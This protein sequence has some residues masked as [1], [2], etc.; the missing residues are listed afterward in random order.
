MSRIKVP[1]VVTVDFETHGIERRPNYPPKPVGV[2]IQYPG[3]RAPTYFAWA[4]PAEN[5][6]SLQE[7]IKQVQRAWKSGLPLL[8]QNGKFD[9]DVAETHCAVKR[10]EWSM[11]HDTLFLIFLYDPHAR[12]FSLKPSAEKILGIT[13]D[14]RDA[15]R[16]WVM[17]HKREIEH[18]YGK[19]LTPKEWGAY[20]SEAPGKLVGRYAQGDVIRTLKLFKHLYPQIA[21]AGMLEAYDRER[22]LM[23]ILLEN[24]RV[25]MRVDVNTLEHDVKEYR[26]C[27]EY[28]DQWLRK[29]LRAPSLNVDSDADMAAAL[30]SAGV[31]TNFVKTPTGK[32]SVSKANLTH[33]L[34]TDKQVFR[35]FGYRNRL[36]TCLKM[37]MEPWLLGANAEN[38]IST[39]WN[40]VRQSS[41][42]GNNGTRTGRPSTSSPNF[43]NLSKSFYDKNDGY[44]H[45]LRL[46]TLRELP[47][48]R[49][50][51]LPDKGHVFLHRDYSQQEL[52][53]LAYFENDKLLTAY[54]ANPRLDIHE[55]VGNA[56]QQITG[57]HLE[58]RFVKI[59]NFGLLYGMG[60]GKLAQAMDIE[61]KD[62][63][64]IKNAQLKALPGLRT[65]QHDIEER[66]NVNEPI[67]TIGGRAYYEEDPIII[68][69]RKISFVYKLLNYLIQGSAADVTKD[70]LIRYDALRKSGRFL[71][72]VYDEINVSAP[73]SEWKQ[74]MARLRKAMEEFD[75]DVPMLSDGKY[76]PSWANLKPYKE[77]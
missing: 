35:V 5:N 29:K 7:G 61:V 23:P 6:C 77:N 42:G 57:K 56:I 13:P 22:K 43:L 60:L 28:A 33:D 63:R 36:T 71:V 68:N 16:D 21:E 50:Y 64:L 9:V 37:F 53:L 62:A 3:E 24:E 44:E 75:I 27:L 34:F 8:F 49:R 39:S 15:V 47:L 46:P 45:P 2:S 66:A 48:V 25:G 67:H 20:I 11:Y 18:K 72:T 30:R 32:D 17:E 73:R 74:E 26:V 55:Y 51:I 38:Y 19:T 12:T 52:R 70:A 14:E 54:K 76:G 69:G 40:Q 31:V 65:L 4:H 41:S 1:D 59:L 10:L 58:R